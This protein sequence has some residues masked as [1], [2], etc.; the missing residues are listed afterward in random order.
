MHNQLCT[1]IAYHKTTRQCNFKTSGAQTP[2]YYTD[3]DYYYKGTPPAGGAAYPPYQVF[4]NTDYAGQGDGLPQQNGT[5]AQCEAACNAQPTCTGIAYHK[6]TSQCNFKTSGAQNP[7]YYTDS[8]YYYKGTP[9]SGG[10]ASPPY[11]VLK[12]TNYGGQ[13]D[14]VAPTQ[15]GNPVQCEAA[16]NGIANCTA[17]AFRKS[18]NT[19][20]FKNSNVQTPNYDANIDYYYK[21]ATPP[22]TV[23]YQV[24][25][26]TDYGGQGDGIPTQHGV[27]PA[28]CETLCNG[29]AGCAAVAFQKS[30]G[31]CI[32]KNGNVQTPSF[33]ADIDYYYKGGAPPGKVPYQVYRNTDYG[34]QGDGIPLQSGLPADCETMCN[35]IENCVAFAFSKSGS[36][37]FFKTSDV[38]TPNLNADIDYYY[39]GPAPPGGP[40][41]PPP[42]VYKNSNFSGK[43]IQSQMPGQMCL[44][45]S[46]GAQNPVTIQQ[47]S[48]TNGGGQGANQW[49]NATDTSI[50]IGTHGLCLDSGSD[51]P[52]QG[53]HVML[54]PC[55]GNQHQNFEF[56]GSN[57]GAIRFTDI[58]NNTMCVNSP[59]DSHAPGTQMILWPCGSGDNDHWFQN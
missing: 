41:K 54:W 9:P 6:S 34:G 33:N 53:D 29:I 17:V 37:C 20:F 26:N 39:K 58:N 1:G 51:I 27:T 42:V 52:N 16:C 14:G 19:C 56:Q 30:T 8:D 25:P 55:N 49:S 48:G 44:D 15:N 57:N 59:G 23:S 12:N 2:N 38:H 7:N 18:D 21:G 46:G 45:D 36:N 43:I 13:G 11:Q 10:A 3:S 50:G 5:P 40:A 28:Q 35:G 22:G 4:N 32:F 47:C 31:N 24:L